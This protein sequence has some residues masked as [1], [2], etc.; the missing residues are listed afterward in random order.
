MDLFQRNALRGVPSLIL[1]V[2]SLAAACS[3]STTEPTMGLQVTA[4]SPNV[5]STSGGTAI[6]IT[7][8][9]FANDASVTIGGVAATNV[10]VQNSTTLTAVTA[11]EP[12]GTVDVTV[13]SGGRSATLTSGFGF[14]AP[15]GANQP[16]VIGNIRSIG[17]RPGQPT[18]FGDLNE[19]VTLLADVSDAETPLSQLTYQWTGPGTFGGNTP[20]T[21]WTLPASVSPVPSPVTATLTVTEVFTEGKLTH[22][23]TSTRT[24]AMQVHD[25]QNEIFDIGQDFLTLFSQ[26]NISTTDV[27]HSFSP[28]CDGGKGRQEEKDDTDR[29]RLELVEDFSKFTISRLPPVT[30]H[31]DSG[32]CPPQFVRGDGCSGFR[33]HWEATYKI[34]ANGHK[35]GD[36]ETTNGIDYV[37]AVLENNQWRLCYSRFEGT[38][39]NPLT[40]E[41]RFVSGR[42]R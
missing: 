2:A 8:N 24:F 39:T 35:A 32:V 1:V 17:S 36:H 19:T 16:P 22:T 34:A 10:V 6:T 21:S 20:T 13:T 23:N 11:A 26:S 41:I 40:G 37:S 3:K 25:S 31:F 5:G 29:N 14:V 33:V 28:T 4:V 30:F 18:G 12:A 27:L 15:S 42:L 7:G 9:D 38:V